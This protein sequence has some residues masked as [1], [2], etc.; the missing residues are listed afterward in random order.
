MIGHIFNPLP[1][2]VPYFRGYVQLIG[3]S[4]VAPNVEGSPFPARKTMTFVGSWQRTRGLEL[5][6][7]VPPKSVPDFTARNGY[8]LTHGNPKK[9]IWLPVSLAKAL[10]PVSFGKPAF[11]SI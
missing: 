10:T 5:I 8:L 7:S 2:R 9:H 3:R 4:K 1:T 11:A 6:S